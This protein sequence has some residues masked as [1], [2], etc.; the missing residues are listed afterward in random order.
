MSNVNITPQAVLLTSGQAVTFSATDA[1]NQPIS[2]TWSLNP[3]A[4][5]LL[6]PPIS[7]AAAQAPGAQAP[8]ATYVAPLVTAGQTIALIASTANQ[9][10][11]ATITLTPDAI[12]IV[13]SKVDL[14]PDQSQQFVAVVAGAPPP[15]PAQAEA[16]KWILSPPVGTLLQTGVYQAPSDVQDSATVNVIAT[17]PSLGKQAVATINLCSP[18]WQ[19]MG[20]NLLGAYLLLVFCVVFLIVGLWPPALP[21]ADSAKAARIEA[22]RT[23]DDK[24][25]TLEKA[26]ADAGSAD[27]ALEKLKAD[28]S[29][30]ASPTNTTPA[31]PDP[32]A[33]TLEA[34]KA[35]S[36]SKKD[37][38]QRATESH[39][40]ASKDLEKKRDVEDRTNNP[41]VETKLD[42]HIYRELD[43]LWLVLLAG[44]LGS[45]L[46]M[47][48]S[49]TD[50]IGN[51][52]I[53]S[54]WAWWYGFRPF[55]GAGLA[56]VFYAAVRGGL[57]AVATGSNSAAADLNPF[58]LVAMGALVG[59]FSKA[60]TQKLGEVF[61]TLFKS[62]KAKESKDK[63]DP[64]TQP[65]PKPTTGAT[66]SSTTGNSTATK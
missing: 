19:G 7:N 24:T 33:P 25:A 13:P 66:G 57:M 35:L 34:A 11:S 49:Y 5:T 42:P 48:Q 62:D 52:T 37:I 1:N 44:S 63:L 14:K 60:A 47:G 21:S 3:Q 18:P 50:F 54:S 2:V 29:K 16:I 56:L 30:P 23:L 53:K 10:A 12:A 61:D 39:D 46:H 20:V 6:I 55:I 58:G 9:S 8:S 43:F 36:I 17:S 38:L 4:G 41:I 27:A 31:K 28:S 65:P 59:M 32:S 15:T 26:E 45:F 22:E 64:S 51:R 40:F